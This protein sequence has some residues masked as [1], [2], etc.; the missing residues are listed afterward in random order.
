[1]N[2]L[3][4]GGGSGGPVAPLLAVAEEIAIFNPRAKFLLVGS[5]LEPEKIMAAQAKIPFRAIVAGKWR[6]YF[7]FANFLTPFQVSAGFIQ[8]LRILKRFRPDCVFGAGSFVQ[9]PL[10]FAARLLNIPVVLHQQDVSPG[11]ANTL[12]Q[13]AASRITVTFEESLTDFV[14]SAGLF[15]K[16]KQDKVILTGNP[17]RLSIKNADKSSALE[18]FG[19]KNNLPVLYAVGGG[20]GSQFINNLIIE[21]LPALSKV[22]QIIHSIGPGKLKINHSRYFNYRPYEFVKEAGL[23]YAAA[24]FVLCRAGLSTITELSTLKKVAVVIPLPNSHQEI[25]AK[26]LMRHQ[27]AIVLTQDKI[28]SQNFVRLLRKLLFEPK[29]QHAL[30]EN[31]SFIMPKNSGKKIAE[32]IIKLIMERKNGNN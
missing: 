32:I 10:V 28:H 27:A 22:A 30:K 3:L 11:L 9:V 25:N 21:A 7:S 19:L 16:K 12:C 17:C 2:I 26:L 20:T 29:L 31:I 5:N 8:S 15:Y 18:Y 23:A 24:D 14:Q 1:M 4:V 6:R 13:F